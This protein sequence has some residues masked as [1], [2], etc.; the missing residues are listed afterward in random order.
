VAFTDQAALAADTAFQGRVRV[1]LE[2]AAEQ[3]AAEA[4]GGMDDVVYG[5]RQALASAVLTS[6]AQDLLPAFVWAVTA[7]PAISGGS[8][9]SDIQFTVNSVWNGIAQIRATD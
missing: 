9:D 1:A 3:I 2:T 8:T 7:N 5:K 6:A 4:K